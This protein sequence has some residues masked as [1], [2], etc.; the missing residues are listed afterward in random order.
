MSWCSRALALAAVAGFALIGTVSGGVAA[1]LAHQ[2]QLAAHALKLK[3]AGYLTVG[4]DPTYPPMESRDP[5]SG[6][7]V[8]ADIDLAS[9]LAKAMHLKGAK[10]V[11]NS[12]DSIIPAL[13][14]GNFDVIMSSMNDTPE[15]AKKIAFV[16]YMR[17]TEGIVVKTSSSIHADNFAGMCGHSVSVESGTTE[18]FDMDTANKTCK[19]KIDIKAFTADTAAF[20]AFASGHADAYSGDLPVCA[21]YIKN[22]HGSLRLAGKPISAG[23]DYG[24]GVTKGNK[25]LIATLKKALKTIE[26]NG[27]YGRILK[28]WGVAGAKL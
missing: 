13:Q 10:I 12:F 9:A 8:G 17:A 20:Q 24:I 14:R 22:H 18:K 23:Q 1:P 28:K 25:S 15:R 11:N 27:Q 26:S 7:Y 3:N 16:D 19:K 4:T 6:Q 21:L 5:R 2:P